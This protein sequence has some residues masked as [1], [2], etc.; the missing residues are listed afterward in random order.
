MFPLKAFAFAPSL[1]RSTADTQVAP[2]V[3]SFTS[4]LKHSSGEAYSVHMVDIPALLPCS[5]LLRGPYP[6]LRHTTYLS[7]QEQGPPSP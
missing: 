6:H 2:L 4:Q 7:G 5:S 3:I 1:G